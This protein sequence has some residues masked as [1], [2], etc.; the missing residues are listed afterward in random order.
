VKV[1]PESVQRVV[2]NVVDFDMH[3]LFE[4]YS[5]TESLQEAAKGTFESVPESTVQLR[6]HGGRPLMLQPK[7]G[8][9]FLD[10]L[11]ER[12]WGQPATVLEKLVTEFQKK[13][14]RE[15]A[16]PNNLY[17]FSMPSEMHKH[18]EQPIP[19]EK[20]D[21][22]IEFNRPGEGAGSDTLKQYHDRGWDPSEAP[23]MSE[24]ILERL[25][26]PP[27]APYTTLKVHPIKVVRAY[28]NRFKG[29]DV[30]N[31]VASFLMRVMPVQI[32]LDEGM[33]REA[34]KLGDL[35]HPMV[36]NKKK[37]YHPLEPE[38]VSVRLYRAEP[39]QARWTFKATSGGDTY[40]V[41]FQFRPS[42]TQRDVKKLD[43]FTSCNCP[44]WV[45]YG[46]QYNA[47]MKDY[48]FGPI[49]LKRGPFG[50][51]R[52][53]DSKGLFSVCKHV[54]RCI[55][56]VSQYKLPMIAEEVRE[57]LKKERKTRV[58]KVE[59][60]D[61]KITI[62][63]DLQVQED[64]PEIKKAIKGWGTW[65]PMRRRRFI[66]ELQ[67]PDSVAYFAYKFPETATVYVADRLKAMILKGPPEKKAEARDQLEEII[68]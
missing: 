3:N 15:A 13:Q 58:V 17:D 14:K 47:H 18:Q 43:V 54:L 60:E 41:V 66:N 57:R 61:Y 36:Y 63:K 38:G 11:K 59:P 34:A 48:L 6:Y 65:S 7:Y 62:P 51:P 28:L 39:A 19:N 1:S 52:V 4:P 27:K 45:F 25:M 68:A 49:Q 20:L 16:D 37:G 5:W 50:A 55:P 10:R 30:G 67:D 33:H 42:G 56:I 9:N 31:V 21:T 40:S 64:N 2:A 24:D 53:R 8:P 46:A 23:E 12:Q 35:T 44:S 26:L 22:F 32:S 29:P